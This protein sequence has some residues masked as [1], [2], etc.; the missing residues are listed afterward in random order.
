[1]A[2]GRRRRRRR[3]RPNPIRTGRRSARTRP[4]G[5]GSRPSSWRR[6]S[7]AAPAR[8]RARPRGTPQGPADA[9]GRR[10]AASCPEPRARAPAAQPSRTPHCPAREARPRTPRACRST[11]SAMC[12]AQSLRPAS[13]NSRVP[14]S[15]STIHTRARSRRTRSSLDS[16]ERIASSGRASRKHGEDQRVRL[17][18]AVVLARAVVPGAGARARPAAAAIVRGELVVVHPAARGAVAWQR[19]A[20]FRRR[21]A[22]RA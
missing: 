18:I 21:R 12:T 6:P 4:H 2:A 9:C 15:G 10:A 3:A 5:P 17:A 11:T 8:R 1:M 13:P 20:V 19:V 14:S 7:R 16:S 22:S